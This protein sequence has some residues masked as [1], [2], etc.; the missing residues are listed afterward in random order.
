MI[1]SCSE[2]QPVGEFP[3]VADIQV[4]GVHTCTGFIYNSRWV[5]TAASCINRYNSF[6]YKLNG[7][8]FNPHFIKKGFGK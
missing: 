7:H 6:T 1:A 4:K 5:V 3:Y 8:L 2:M